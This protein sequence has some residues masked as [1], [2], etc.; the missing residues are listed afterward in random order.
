MCKIIHYNIVRDHGRLQTTHTLVNEG[1]CT[2]ED[3]QIMEYYAAVQKSGVVLC[4]DIQRSLRYIAKCKKQGTD[5]NNA[6]N[7]TFYII[8]RKNKNL[9]SC[10]YRQILEGFIRS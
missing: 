10:L 9:Y 7:A 3:I 4:I 2:M 6:N 5:N 8:Q 1:L